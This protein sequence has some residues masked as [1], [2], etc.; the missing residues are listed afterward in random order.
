MQQSIEAAQ[1]GG[2]I[3]MIGVLSGL[4]RQIAI[5][6]IFGTRREALTAPCPE[7]G[8]IAERDPELRKQPHAK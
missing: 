4:E 8:W 7:R 3:L 2:R 1:V 5:P 6:N